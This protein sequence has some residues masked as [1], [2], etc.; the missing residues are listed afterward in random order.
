MLDGQRGGFK[1]EAETV[2]SYKGREDIS[3]HA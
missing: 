3:G 1:E 2:K